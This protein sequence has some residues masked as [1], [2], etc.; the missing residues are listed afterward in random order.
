MSAKQPLGCIGLGL[1]GLPMALRLRIAMVAA[2]SSIV[3]IARP[4]LAPRDATND[5]PHQMVTLA[6][7][8]FDG[9][10]SRLHQGHCPGLVR[11]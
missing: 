9:P 11:V 3:A 2:L 4:A 10:C 6:D 7:V 8:G 1:M 5:K